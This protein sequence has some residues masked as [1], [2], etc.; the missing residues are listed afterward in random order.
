MLAQ[1]KPR[2]VSEARDALRGAILAHRLA[3]RSH[4]AAATAAA[5]ASDAVGEAEADLA[6]HDALDERIG[7]HHA[8]RIE[9]WARDGG[10]RP[11]LD[12]PQELVDAQA[13]RTAARDH[14]AALRA[15]HDVLREKVREAAAELQRAEDARQAAVIAVLRDQGD[16]LAAQLRDADERAASLRAQLGELLGLWV[17]ALKETVSPL[18]FFGK[19]DRP[20]PAS[21]AML[22]ALSGQVAQHGAPAAAAARWAAFRAALLTDADARYED[23][24]P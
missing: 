23:C 10:A 5:R 3:E 15:A 21:E 22:A 17:P 13:A 7:A 8:E 24:A 4:E 6:T 18:H 1:T 20:F 11:T 12:L 19:S 9:A 2:E 14:L 16:A